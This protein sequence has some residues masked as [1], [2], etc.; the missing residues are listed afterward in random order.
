MK[1]TLLSLGN[2]SK[3]FDGKTVLDSLDLEIFD[4]EFITLLGPSGCGKTTLLRMMAGFEHP[5]EGGS[6]TLGGQDL[7]HTPPEHRPLNTVFQNYALFP[8]MSVFDNVAYGLKM[9]KRPKEEIRQRVEEALAMVQ[10]EDFARRKPHQ[11]S[12]GQQ[13]RVAIARAVVK[14]PKMLLLDEPLSALDF[15]LRRTMQVELK[16]LQRE[17]GIT[18]V[19]VTHDQEEALSM[20]DRVVVL[21][22]GHIQQLGTPRE[23]YER[24]A[25]LFTARFVGETNFFPG[26]VDAANGDD[27]ITVDVFGLKRTFRKP[28]FPVTEGQGLHVLLRPEDIRVLA[29]EDEDGVAGKVVE[30]NYKG[31]TLDSVIHLSDGTEVLASEFFDEDDPTFDYR[32]G[33][34]VKVSWVD[35]WEWLLPEEHTDITEE[36]PID[37]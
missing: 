32:L 34:P 28:D 21:K 14:R 10:L 20:S 7:T 11:L 22:D 9:E 26:R 33:E 27:T 36:E 3:Q 12:G 23:V 18:F 30:R 35:G 15:K 24:P 1:Q 19:F 8:H 37:G 17:L 4:G 2:L 29:P 5:D 31:S 13:Q 6:I 16:R 25:N